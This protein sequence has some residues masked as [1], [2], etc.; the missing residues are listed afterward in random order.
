MDLFSLV[1]RLL[2]DKSG[3]EEGIKEAEGEARSF[4]DKLK[5]GLGTAAKVGAAA[6]AA[7][8]TAAVAMG[9]TLVK[10][11]G[12]VAAYGD[13]IDKASQKLGIS[14]EA[15]QEWDAVLQHSGTSID[16]M[17]IGMKT[18]ANKAAEG[19]DAFA[20]LG[21]SAQEAAS[22]SREEL[23]SKTIT[24]LQNVTD[25]NQRAQLAQELFGRSAMELGPLLNTSAEETQAMKDRVH[26]LGGVMS[27]EA[28]KAAAAYQDNLQ[29]MQTAMSG[30]KRSIVSEFIPGLSN[31]MSAF[32]N[33]LAGEDPG[34][35]LEAG[36]D[37]IVGAMDKTVDKFVTIGQRIIPAIVDA[38]VKAAP[39]LLDGA[40]K[41]VLTLGQAIIANLPN[42]IKAGLEVIV[43]LANAIAASLPELI[44][45]IVSVVMEIVDVLTEPD[46]LANLLDAAIAIMVALAE[47]LVDA[48][49]RLIERV[50]EIILNLVGAFIRNAPKLLEAGVK[51]IAVF[52]KG[53][54]EGVGSVLSAINQI[55]SNIVQGIGQLISGAWE[56]GKDMIV[57]FTNGIIAF[58]SKPIDA[59]RGLAGR[60]KSFLGFSEPEEGPLSN[61]H[62]YAPDM[63]QLFAKGIKDN[64]GVI[65]DA[66][67]GAFNLR[68]AI[69]S[70]VAP[71]QEVAVPAAGST[72][73]RMMMAIFQ[74]NGSEVG[75]V[76]T[77]LVEAEQA[78]VGVKLSPVTGG[79]Y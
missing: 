75:R 59:V 49:P 10:E 14:A 47:G 56:W 79:A 24:A 77:P 58:I 57:N 25:E 31:L 28:V 43:T 6:V 72:A 15:Y 16:S 2:L 32:T 63:M 70:S 53:L 40:G 38:I 55:G 51:L 18:L 20:A 61:F 60:I 78:R 27:D 42:L 9:R 17:G 3:Y 64:E 76:I 39:A 26:E 1:A 71:A 23:F 46:T 30:V 54:V 37:G 8:G 73:P 19:S 29:D 68:P 7:V 52:A 21:I 66:I 67:S 33:I 74:L 11:A 13:N 69:A 62:T 34:E 65:T 45:T 36:I 41:L 22:M 12:E 48:V 35:A 5:S 4:G 50:P 44:P